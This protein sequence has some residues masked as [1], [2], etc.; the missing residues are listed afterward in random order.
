MKIPEN[1]NS[2]N[3]G[4]IGR[5]PTVTGQTVF[6]NGCGVLLHCSSVYEAQRIAQGAR[7]TVGN[8]FLLQGIE[9]LRIQSSYP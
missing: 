6:V 8:I 4:V 2:S 9:N 1:T 7:E 5:E 3:S